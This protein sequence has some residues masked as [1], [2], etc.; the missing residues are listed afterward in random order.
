M[1]GFFFARGSC[2]GFAEAPGCEIIKVKLLVLERD[3]QK[4]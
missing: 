2:V 4:A 1:G 3:F